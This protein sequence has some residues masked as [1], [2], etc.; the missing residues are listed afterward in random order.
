MMLNAQIGGN[1][2]NPSGANGSCEPIVHSNVIKLKKLT[3]ESR[4]MTMEL[5]PVTSNFSYDSIYIIRL[6]DGYRNSIICGCPS[7]INFTVQP[8]TSYQVWV[9]FKEFG[10]H[11]GLALGVTTPADCPA[12][13]DNDGDG[14]PASQD[15]NDDD[16]RYHQE[17]WWYADD[18]ADGY[19]QDS[20]R[21]FSCGPPPQRRW[22]PQGGDCNDGDAALN[23]T[24]KWYYDQ[25]QD[26]Y[27]D[28]S[29][30]IT[31]CEQPNDK[32]GRPYVRQSGDEC[33]F[34]PDLIIKGSCNCAGTNPDTDGDGT[35]DCQDG[36]P[37]DPNK[38]EPG[39][40][41]CHKKLQNWYYDADDDGIGAGD[42]VAA[43][44]KPG[45]KYGLVGGDVCPNK[46]GGY[47]TSYRDADNDGYGNPNGGCQ[48]CNTVCGNGYVTNANDCNDNNAAINPGAS[49]TC[50]GQDNNCNNI[51]D[52]GCGGD[53]CANKGGDSDGDMVC[54]SDDCAPN[55]PNYPKPVGTACDDGNPATEDDKI[56]ADGCTCEGDLNPCLLDM[57]GDGIGDCED[58]CPSVFNPDQ[59]DDDNNGI[60]NAC[61]VD[62]PC[63]ATLNISADA[64][65][66][67]KGE[68]VRLDADEGFEIYAWENGASTASIIVTPSST[69]TYTLEVT[70]PSGCQAISQITIQVRDKSD[71]NC[72]P[73]TGNAGSM[74]AQLCA[75]ATHSASFKKKTHTYYEIVP[76]EFG[77]MSSAEDMHPYDLLDGEFKE[78]GSQVDKFYNPTDKFSKLITYD[79][80]EDMVESWMDKPAAVVLGMDGV[81]LYEC[82]G[83]MVSE[84]AYDTENAEFFAEIYA[85]ENVNTDALV[86]GEQFPAL[87]LEDYALLRQAGFT[88]EGAPGFFTIASNEEMRL[89]FNDRFKTLTEYRFD[90]NGKVQF[91]SYKRWIALTDEGA[92]PTDG[93]GIGRP[94]LPNEEKTLTLLNTQIERTYKTLDNGVCVRAIRL[95][96][97]EDF[98]PNFCSQNLQ[99]A[100]PRTSE[101]NA[102]VV[103][104][105]FATEG[106]DFK[107]FPN[108]AHDQVYLLIPA[109]FLQ[110]EVTIELLNSLGQKIT[111]KHLSQFYGEMEQ[112]NIHELNPGTYY[113]RIFNQDN[114]LSQKFLKQ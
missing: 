12:D 39:E 63:P 110:Q 111:E 82:D 11:Q 72:E 69:T 24:T 86:Y 7:T 100:T 87:S 85:P 101:T 6:N 68:S 25:D 81:K 84:T 47:T 65:I 10:L 76:N 21:E 33:P 90:E 14:Y 9:K 80:P 1:F 58:N 96:L 8:Q 60:G 27:G 2:P 49:E 104:P 97:K 105:P 103:P 107:V 88:V 32:N 19:G 91:E 36:C 83:S 67:C 29:D 26:G 5:L 43:C 93:G 38:T 62:A 89:E 17:Q 53:P 92:V 4:K 22:A 99:V 13:P 37:T 54:D 78:V 23:P 71:V 108:P 45:D 3:V 109:S 44:D 56:Q 30:V 106:K 95:E 79:N 61:D 34:N 42:P 114:Q 74:R 64:N 52:E 31:Q 98:R 112:I 94:T 75:T 102:Q 15:C 55:D 20:N 40:C 46:P 50:D 41:G 28:A 16:A 73:C 57:D 66:I 18:D 77:A 35:W 51:I 113:V 70:H 59:A 48:S